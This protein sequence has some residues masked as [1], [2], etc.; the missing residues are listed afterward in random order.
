VPD[1]VP[2]VLTVSVGTTVT[3]AVVWS[4][5]TVTTT[6]DVITEPEAVVPIAVMVEPPVRPYAGS[7][8][9]MVNPVGET[10]TLFESLEIQVTVLVRF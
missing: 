1:P 4:D 5:T 10:D 3:G 7:T 6:E 9:D 8:C 2:I